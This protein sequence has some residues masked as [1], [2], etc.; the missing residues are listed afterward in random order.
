[1]PGPTPPEMNKTSSH[2]F[3][4]GNAEFLLDGKPFQIRSGE[5][6]PN[7]IPKEHWR[8]RLRMAKAMGLNTVSTYVFWS[9]HEIAEGQF[10]F[11]TGNRDLT[12]FCRMAQEEGL[13]VLLRPGPYCCSEYDFGGI[14]PY[15]L[16]YADIR[17]RCMDPRYI[18]A[19]D[20]YLTALADVVRPLQ[21]T[22]GGPV[23]MLQ[24]ENEYGSYGN[25]RD[26]L[27]WV[28]RRWRQLGIT[29]AFY[30][31]DG[32]TAPMMEAGTLPGCAVGLDPG[33]KLKDW[34]LARQLNPDVPI[35]CSEVYPGWQTHWGEPWARTSTA[36]ICRN[37]KFQMDHKKS[38][39][40]YMF[41][42]GANFG[43]T[44]GANSDRVEGAA[45]GMS[46]NYMPTITSYDYDSPV[47]EDGHATAKF[48]G[49]RD[50]I[51]SYLP[52]DAKPPAIPNPPM[53]MAIPEITLQRWTSLWDNMPSPKTVVQPATF[54]RFGQYHGVMLYRTRL[55]G[56]KSGTLFL[57]EL[58]DYALVFLD[59]RYVGALDRRLGQ[60]SIE[61]PPCESKTPVLEILVEA[62]GHVNFGEFM[63]DRKGITDHVALNGMTLMNWEQYSFPLDEEWIQ[64][65]PNVDAYTQRQGGFFKGVFPLAEIADTYLDM[66]RYQKGYV[67]VNG[68]NLGRYW[69]IG[70]Q[71]RLY[72]PA[73]WLQ[74]GKNVI[75]VLD[76]LQGKA[77][78]VNGKE[79]LND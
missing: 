34:E 32:P 50:L 74:K 79:T 23:L 14:P 25:D 40:L 22:K 26:Y 19:A 61:L 36:D 67:W 48:I 18:K 52:A 44:A 76:L 53:R 29:T 20:R 54:E 60:N 37:V 27:E 63:I 6:H 3:Q 12:S 59:G 7:R 10:D 24:I 66:S 56:H 16:R 64:S 17:I 69:N 2:T 68:H 33:T 1:M 71:E 39:N 41:A 43:F 5:I 31:G 65:L 51:A 38:F 78:S 13:W 47:A 30:T 70:P 58:H 28:H 55:V 77:E 15:L 4:L 49:L 72:C 46:A 45:T 35:F 62:M 73:C 57:R 75:V 21:V 42:G 9:Y 11:H 8:H